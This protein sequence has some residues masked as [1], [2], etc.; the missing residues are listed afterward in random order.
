MTAPVHNLLA[1]G[2]ISPVDALTASAS[3]G[4]VGSGT[5]SA[6][7]AIQTD[8][9]IRKTVQGVTTTIGTWLL[10]G[11]NSDYEVYL[12]G[13]GDSPGTLDTWLALSS[14]RSWGLSQGS[15]GSKDFTGTYYLRRVGSSINL[16]SAALTLSVSFDV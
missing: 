5:A 15:L 10:S 4:V 14:T 8:G 1:S 16:D 11:S 2:G 6:T 9:L 3:D 13:A 12:T 7:I